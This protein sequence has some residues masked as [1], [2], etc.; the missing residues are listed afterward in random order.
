[1]KFSIGEKK[2]GGGSG[3]KKKNGSDFRTGANLTDV[4]TF[5]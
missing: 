3:K 5:F 4:K 2:G 1:L